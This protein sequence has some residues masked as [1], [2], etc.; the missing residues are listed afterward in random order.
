MCSGLVTGGEVV[1]VGAAVVVGAGVV[2]GFDVDAVRSPVP[3]EQAAAATV[4]I[5]TN[6]GR[7]AFTC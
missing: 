5:P 2:V 1:V 4:R 7:T 3:L 6:S